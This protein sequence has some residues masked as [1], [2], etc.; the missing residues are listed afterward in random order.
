MVY[1]QGIGTTLNCC[2]N[3]GL[4]CGHTRDNMGHLSATFNLQTVWAIVFE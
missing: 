3:Q 2:I 1:Q 4:T